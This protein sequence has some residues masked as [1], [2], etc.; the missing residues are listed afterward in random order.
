MGLNNKKR[1]FVDILY[2]LK[3]IR[4]NLFSICLGHLGGY[5]ALGGEMK[6]FRK[7]DNINYINLI[8]SD[9]SY[10]VKPTAIKL[11]YL[12]KNKIKV[13]GIIDSST[14]ITYFPNDLFA[15]L[16]IIL[17]I[18]EEKINSNDFIIMKIMVCVL[19]L[20]IGKK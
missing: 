8:K 17:L 11:T 13:L 20:E 1:S 15:I 16:G 3:I 19:N 18:S 4:R 2:K 7:G 14:P 6:D 12:T 9:N 5:L 10:L